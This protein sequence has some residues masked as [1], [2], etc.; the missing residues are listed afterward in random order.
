AER[1]RALPGS[2]WV[3]VNS[4]EV[5]PRIAAWRAGA[6]PVLFANRMLVEGFD[7]PR[8][9]SIW[10][11]KQSESQILYAQIAGRALRPRP[12]KV[13]RVFCEGP[14]MESDLRAA[15]ARCG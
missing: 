9:A 15:L 10:L 8:C 7:E 1:A 5:S 11:A 6:V 2:A 3:G 14:T 12:G 13:A 4:G